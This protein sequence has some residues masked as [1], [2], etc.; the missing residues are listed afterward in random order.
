MMYNIEWAKAVALTLPIVPWESNGHAGDMQVMIGAV[1]MHLTARQAYCDRGKIHWFV[2]THDSAE[3]T[4]DHADGFPRY[5]FKAEAFA[6]ELE[7]WL[8]ERK[9]WDHPVLAS[10]RATMELLV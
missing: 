4:I 2:E 10:H 7:A 1:E 8:K 6:M 3:I 9:L 5:Y